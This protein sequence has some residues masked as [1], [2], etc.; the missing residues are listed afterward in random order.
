MVGTGT[1]KC[2][3]VLCEAGLGSSPAAPSP[4]AVGKA[5]GQSG[6]PGGFPRGLWHP[7]RCSAEQFITCD[8]TPAL[9]P[10][11]SP[12]TREPPRNARLLQGETR[13]QHP[14]P[15]WP[16][17]AARAASGVCPAANVPQQNLAAGAGRCLGAA[18]LLWGRR[19]GRSHP[20]LPRAP[21]ERVLPHGSSRAS[22]GRGVERGT[23]ALWSWVSRFRQGRISRCTRSGIT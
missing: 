15:H 19:R 1:I 2:L 12:G 20:A 4:R 21:G 10:C 16:L 7:P 23:S 3:T 5:A 13:P 17:P 9:S 11:A 22:H 6:A 18:A 14:A 8:V